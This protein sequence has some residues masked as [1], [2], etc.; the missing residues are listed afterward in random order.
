METTTKPSTNKKRPIDD[1][2]PMFKI[3]I[4]KKVKSKWLNY[5]RNCKNGYNKT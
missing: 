4:V 5:N 1:M 3:K 2:S